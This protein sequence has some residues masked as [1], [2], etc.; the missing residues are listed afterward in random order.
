M[1]SAQ[2]RAGSVECGAR[3]DS[4]PL[5]LLQQNA[6]RVIV[7]ALLLLFGLVFAFPFYW[8]LTASV[9]DSAEI[10]ALPPT[11]YPHSFTIDAYGRVWSGKFARYFLNSFVYAGSVTVIDVVTS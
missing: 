2:T 6:G 9:K 5:A 10:R 3:P 1:A 4:T 8:V 7:L 11:W